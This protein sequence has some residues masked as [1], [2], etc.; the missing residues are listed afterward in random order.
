MSVGVVADNCSALTAVIGVGERVMSEMM[1]EPV[2][3]TASVLALC[4]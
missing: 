2:T 1:R 3:I 4:A